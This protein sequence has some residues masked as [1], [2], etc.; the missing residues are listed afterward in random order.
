ML[1]TGAELVEWYQTRGFHGSQVFDAIP[2]AL[3]LCPLLVPM[4][5]MYS[6]SMYVSCEGVILPDLSDRA[7]IIVRNLSGPVEVP[8]GDIIHF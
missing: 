4:S 6:I 8:H 7:V 5:G 2:F 3:L 1:M